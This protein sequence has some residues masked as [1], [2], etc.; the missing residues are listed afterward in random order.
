MALLAAGH[1]NV[2]AGLVA[3]GRTAELSDLHPAL[4]RRYLPGRGEQ[5]QRIAYQRG[6]WTVRDGHDTG[7]APK[8]PRGTLL[9]SRHGDEL[10]ER[11]M[12]AY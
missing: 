1:V 9:D 6:R 3:G 8:L 11:I 2:G 7:G 4:S 5:Q 10:T 12:H